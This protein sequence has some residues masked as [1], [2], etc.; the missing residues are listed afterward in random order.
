MRPLN[1]LRAGVCGGLH[2]I[3]TDIDDTLTTDGRLTARAYLAMERLMDSGVEVLPVTGRPAGWCDHIARLWPVAGVVGEN[4]AF[5]FRYDHDRREM[6]RCYMQSYG[7]RSENRERLATLATR[8]LDSNPRAAIAADQPYRE[9]DVAIDYGEDV[10]RL[11]ADAVSD[12]VRIFESAGATAKVSSIHVNGW[13]GDYDKLTMSRRFARECLHRDLD[14]ER[15]RFLFV[16]DS[17]NDAPMFAHFPHS[18][19]VANV[20]EFADSLTAPPRFVTP[21]RGGAGFAEVADHVL[22]AR[23]KRG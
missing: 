20:S 11:D 19:G 7:E 10:A 21:S 8:I 4:G 2:G 5:Y 9:S 3:L 12:I 17:P 1:E 13:F 6:A 22:A 23:I 18:I 16:G 15:E 14:L